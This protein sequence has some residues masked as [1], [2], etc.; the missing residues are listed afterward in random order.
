VKSELE[1]LSALTFSA[2]FRRL[3]GPLA[4]AGSGP[5]SLIPDGLSIRHLDLQEIE[6]YSSM[7]RNRLLGRTGSRERSLASTFPMTMER[8][9]AKGVCLDGCV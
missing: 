4:E 2:T 3:I 6:R 5:A 7:I 9:L 1:F 8:I